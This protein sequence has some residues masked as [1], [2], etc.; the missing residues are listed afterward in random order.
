MVEVVGEAY[1]VSPKTV[2]LA[3]LALELEKLY[4]VD[5]KK[6]QGMRTDIPADSAGMLGLGKKSRDQAAEKYGISSSAV[7]RAK[8]VQ[9][10]G[11][12]ELFDAVRSGD[13]SVVVAELEVWLGL[14]E[15][16]VGR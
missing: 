1:G 9:N 6:R 14:V 12:P 10:R 8:V 5:A 2:E 11:V 4:A 7:K 13:T 16:V 15:F 3:V